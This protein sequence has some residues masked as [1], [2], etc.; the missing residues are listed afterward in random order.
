MDYAR[1]RIGFLHGDLGKAE[2]ELWKVSAEWV[3]P[4]RVLG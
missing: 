4:Q 1:P 2:T 3:A